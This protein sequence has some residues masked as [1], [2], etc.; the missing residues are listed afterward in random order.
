MKNGNGMKQAPGKAEDRLSDKGENSQGKF[1]GKESFNPKY[2]LLQMVALQCAFYLQFT[3]V[4]CS[5]FTV[6]GI[7]RRLLMFF[8]SE[9]YSFRNG[10]GRVLSAC[11]ALTSTSM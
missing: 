2:I 10:G 5:L 11:L 6:F 8:A 7:P 4:A 3:F 1:Y 9:A